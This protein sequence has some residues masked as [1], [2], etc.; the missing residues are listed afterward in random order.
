MGLGL[1]GLG[2]GFG[3]E[4]LRR[5]GGNGLAQCTTTGLEFCLGFRVLGLRVLGLRVLGF[6]V[7]PTI[8][9]WKAQTLQP[10]IL[11]PVTLTLPNPV[12]PEPSTPKEDLKKRI[13]VRTKPHT[14]DEV[15]PTLP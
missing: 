15:N 12:H 10:I 8:K 7:Y 14:V 13:P 6:R 9:S 2:T 1:I 4:E 5:Q 11:S 3:L